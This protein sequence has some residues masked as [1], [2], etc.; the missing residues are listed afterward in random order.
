MPGNPEHK[1]PPSQIQ[2]VSGFSG[3]FKQYEP[4]FVSAQY[5][6]M[7]RKIQAH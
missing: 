5:L 1:P 2:P 7:G 4:I 6:A 3:S